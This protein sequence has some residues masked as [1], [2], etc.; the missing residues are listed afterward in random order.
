MVNEP[1]GILQTLPAVIIG[2]AS[3][4]LP[5]MVLPLMS[6][7]ESIP[8]SVEEAA[9]NLGA[10]RFQIFLKILLPLSIPGLVSGSILVYLISI[11]A[12][13]VPALMGMPKVRM[14]GNQVY[15]AVLVSFN[16]P[17]AASI[18]IIMIFFTFTILGFYL[19]WVRK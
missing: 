4:L 16:W 14:L 6:A 11:S 13:I 9:S 12:L 7:I 19:K 18:S 2:I 8:K 10:N 5:Y 17:F 15:D 1:I 3:I